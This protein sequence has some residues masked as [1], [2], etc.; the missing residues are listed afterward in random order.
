M[1]LTFGTNESSAAA[2]E[3]THVA[4]MLIVLGSGSKVAT[5]AAVG[6][7][8][9]C[10]G[11]RRGTSS[12]SSGRRGGWRGL[13]GRVNSAPLREAAQGRSRGEY[14]ELPTTRLFT[15][16]ASVALR[17]EHLCI[18]ECFK[19]LQGRLWANAGQ[20]TRH[21][22]APQHKRQCDELVSPQVQL[23]LHISHL[24]ALRGCLQEREFVSE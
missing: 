13:L 4:A 5:H 21:V 1:A 20:A 15:E 7:L 18:S 22:V 2:V 24:N 3:A 9:A 14:D 12:R 11:A 16:A 17:V 8:T 19:A 6:R 23:P 10:T